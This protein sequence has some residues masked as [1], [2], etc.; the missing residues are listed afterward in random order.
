[1]NDPSTLPVFALALAV[2][3][4]EVV[5]L[6]IFEPRYKAMIAH[7]R[8]LQAE[9]GAGEF[10]IVHGDDR[11]WRPVGCVMRIA[12]IL[13]TYD[14]GRLDL[15]AVGHRRCAVA[16]TESAEAFPVG[17][18]TPYEDDARD[19]DEA[20][21]NDVFRYHR[22]LLALATGKEPEPS[23]YAG[24]KSLS[25]HVM[26]TAGLGLERKQEIL[27]LSAENER[28]R[29]LAGHLKEAGDTLLRAHQLV[30]A[31]QTAIQAAALLR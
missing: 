6:H 15:V 13:K 27:E 9:G 16:W 2:C 7:C 10:V 11:E 12:K 26:P 22:R 8:S 4:G 3:P 1:M 18:V 30:N 28:L 20:L 24:L 5:P 25:F 23:E 14:D 19:W 21:A 17:R 29:A 31:V